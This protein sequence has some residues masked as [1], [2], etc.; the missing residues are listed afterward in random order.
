MPQA[1]QTYAKAATQPLSASNNRKKTT[2]KQ[3]SEKV[4]EKG[5]IYMYVTAVAIII[6]SPSKFVML[7][8]HGA[9]WLRT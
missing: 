8:P 2:A 7:A 5:L 9:N 3:K 4:S 1:T 6:L